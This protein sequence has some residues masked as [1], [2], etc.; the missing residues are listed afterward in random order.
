MSRNLFLALALAPLAA[1]ANFGP[2]QRDTRLALI[3][4]QRGLDRDLWAPVEDQITVG[5]ECV[6][7]SKDTGLGWETA[8]QYSYDDATVGA[9]DVKSTTDELSVGGRYELVGKQVRP[10]VGA[11]LALV[12]AE[13][14]VSNGGSSASED[15]VSVA[16]Y[17]HAGL[18]IPLG[19]RFF[20]GLDVR[21]LFGS[22]LDLAGVS[23]DAD[24]VQFALTLGSSF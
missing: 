14:E 12:K 15:D 2:E 8:I 6:V 11:G 19:E 24:Y 7:V 3:L 5:A 18:E 16:G 23:A 1:C 17:A 20:V 21:A 9:V 13:M 4:G 10:F 22:D